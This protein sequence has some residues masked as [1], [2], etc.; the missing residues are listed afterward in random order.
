MLLSQFASFS[1][2]PL[3]EVAASRISVA[4]IR[5]PFALLPLSTT[6]GRDKKTRGP[7]GGGDR[8][9]NGGGGGGGGGGRW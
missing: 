6:P 7:G 4:D 8:S 3:L 9:R 1:I 5:L 2:A